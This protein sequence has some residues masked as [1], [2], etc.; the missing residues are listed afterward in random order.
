MHRR[1]LLAAAGLLATTA[2]C[3]AGGRRVGGSGAE[4][5][6]TDPTATE[7]D[8]IP[9]L[10]P[11]EPVPG[12]GD[13]IELRAVEDDEDVEYLPGEEAV[14]YVAAWRSG[15]PGNRSEGDPPDRE[16]VYE[17]VPVERWARIQATSAAGS[18]AAERTGSRLGVDALGGGVTSRVEGRNSTPVVSSTTTKNR[19]G[20]VID[21]SPVSF[22]AL[23][24]ATPASA[25]VTYVVADRR[26]DHEM[27]VYAVHEIIQQM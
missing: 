19:D 15:D 14:R 5:T 24:R 11:N 7:A 12:R 10:E 13:P 16:P 20:E 1:D 26:F 18:T 17:T 27:P 2:G 9:G 22:S 21:E 6:T 8:P 25:T 3:L 23:V 4:T